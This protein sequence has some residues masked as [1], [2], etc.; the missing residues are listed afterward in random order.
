MGWSSAT[1]CAFD[2]NILQPGI[3]I[4]ILTGDHDTFMH[5][6]TQQIGAT[7]VLLKPVSADALKE[8]IEAAVGFSI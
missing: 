7:T 1:K 4:I 3:P 5:E 6:V 8:Q 2:K